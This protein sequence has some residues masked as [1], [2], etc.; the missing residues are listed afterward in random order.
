LVA[1]T[2]PHRELLAHDPE[3]ALAALDAAEAALREGYWIAGYLCYELG[4]A[5]VKGPQRPTLRPLLHLGAFDAPRPERDADRPFTLSPLFPLIDEEA[6]AAAIDAIHARIYDG[7]VYQVNYTVPYALR[8][9]GDAAS[10]WGAIAQ[11][12]GAR[13]QALV[14]DDAGFLLSWSPE[15]FLEFD[16]ERIRTRPMK[17]TAPID[18]V[19]QLESAKNRAEH[20][21]IV[22]LLRNDLR[23]VCD[24][25]DVEALCTIE[26]YPRFATMTSTIGGTVRPDATLRDIFAATFPCGSITGAPKRAAYATIHAL[27]PQTRE[28]YCGAI[29]SLSPQRRGWWNVAIRTAQIDR[30]GYGRFDAGGGIVIDSDAR[31]EWNEIALK[32]A[33]LDRFATPLELWETLASDADAD[34]LDA[35][36]ARLRATARRFRLEFNEALLRDALGDAAARSGVHTLVRVRLRADGTF[37]VATEP[38]AP[39]GSPAP[40]CLSNIR[41]R[42]DDPLLAIKTAWRPAAD[43]AM[44]VALARRCFDAL[45][46]NERGELTEGSRTNL[47]VEISGTL[48]TPPLVCGLLPGI[49]RSR[50]VSEGRV[51]ERAIT[52]ADLTAADA[53]YVGNSARGLV[54]ARLV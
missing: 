1:F 4:A 32:T 48:F 30:D 37:T 28:A 6:Y 5:F 38:M 23:R 45:L 3:S 34:T 36:L 16:G 11:A 51:E 22:D 10:L 49:L 15:L 27:E 46:C 31:A 19:A 18:D 35:H 40:I 8:V 21:M 20:V 26:S 24:D 43:A 7:E 53:I 47:F 42:S 14:E 17:G 29:G 2:N 44:K 13:Y 25:V 9:L 12:T 52:P 41:V 54:P 39:P 50:L 33:F